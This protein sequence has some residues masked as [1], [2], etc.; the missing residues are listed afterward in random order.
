MFQLR[1]DT[2]IRATSTVDIQLTAL[3]TVESAQGIKNQHCRGSDGTLLC[4]IDI[5]QQQGPTAWTA[6][7]TADVCF[8]ALSS[9]FGHLI[10]I[11]LN[12]AGLGMREDVSRIQVSQRKL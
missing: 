2:Q 3:Q 5:H 9:I 7:Y 10:T 12:A 4:L 11:V 6:L 8:V 1:L